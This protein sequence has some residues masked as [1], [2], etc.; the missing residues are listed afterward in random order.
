VA[1]SIDTAKTGRVLVRMGLLVERRR[2]FILRAWEGSLGYYETWKALSDAQR[3]AIETNYPA[4]RVLPGLVKA[5]CA[6]WDG[7][8]TM[9]G[10]ALQKCRFWTWK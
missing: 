9:L 4:P 1:V 7:S 10:L 3:H 8:W 5:G 2:Y 6:T